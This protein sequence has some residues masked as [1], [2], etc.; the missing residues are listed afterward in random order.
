M[1]KKQRTTVI[2]RK[3]EIK[4][5][6]SRHN[7]VKKVVN[8]F[9]KTEYNRK[10]KGVIFKYPVEKLP[11]GHLFISRPGH[12]KNFD[13]KVEITPNLDIGEGSHIEIADDL[14]RKKNAKP[15]GFGNLIKAVSEVYNCNECGINRIISKYNLPKSFKTGAETQIYLKII[16]WL[17][18]MEDIIYWDNEGR[19]F[20][21]N[22]INY[23]I[24]E[25]SKR[26]LNN[27]FKQSKS[28]FGLKPDELK[29][30]MKKSKID[31]IPFQ[32]KA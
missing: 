20:L 3:I 4:G 8:T 15:R 25:R 21:F 14:K 26:R 30:F 31:W 17:F 5:L 7:I 22:F 19:A 11:K 2:G 27:V 12:K 28:R 16:K 9:I 13:F 32:G 24:N 18:I 10:G 1:A 6:W 23:V 29:R